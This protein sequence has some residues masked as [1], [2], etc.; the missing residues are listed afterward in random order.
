VPAPVAAEWIYGDN[1]TLKQIA[2]VSKPGALAEPWPRVALVLA[3]FCFMYLAVQIPGNK[4]QREDFLGGAERGIR[5]RLARLAVYQAV[6][7]PPPR[8]RRP[9]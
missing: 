9:V 4:E 1:A 5:Q 2:D 7:G 8:R 6:A 3:A